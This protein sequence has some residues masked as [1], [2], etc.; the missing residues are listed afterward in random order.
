[1]KWHRDWYKINI[2]NVNKANIGIRGS[3]LKNVWNG[4]YR[5]PSNIAHY[6]PL[7]PVFIHIAH[8]CPGGPGNINITRLFANPE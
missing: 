4:E 7:K 1:M 5:Q 6:C 3:K 2:F 8:Y